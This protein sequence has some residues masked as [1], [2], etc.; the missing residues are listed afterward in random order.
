MRKL[1]LAIIMI[2]LLSFT[3]V[4]Q[5]ASSPSL[6]LKVNGVEVASPFT[7]NGTTYV[8]IGSIAKK[9]GDKVTWFASSKKAVIEKPNKTVVVVQDGSSKAYVNG[10]YLPLKTKVLNNVVVPVDAKAV[11]K[12]GVLYVPVD[13]LSNEKGLAYPV[14]TVTEAGKVV[15]YVGKVPVQGNQTPSTPQK[16]T[17]PS[18]PEAE[19]K[20]YPDGWVAPVLKSSWSPD[21]NK[22]AEILRN[23]LGFNEVLGFSVKGQPN[24]ILVHPDYSSEGYEAL[25]RFS[26]WTDSYVPQ[27]YRIP[28]VAKELFKLYFGNDYMKVWNYFNRGDVP[29]KFTA[30]GR[31]VKTQFTEAD[32]MFYLEVGFKGKKW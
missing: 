25:I 12:N 23:E 8:P 14:K 6:T 31:I 4:A 1:F 24:A 22:N 29:T 7:L 3:V 30:N 10:T 21:P 28:I 20:K 9:M 32:G 26:G 19:G 11:I 13:F 5:G 15:I 17:T 18:K 16:P 27:S 2:F